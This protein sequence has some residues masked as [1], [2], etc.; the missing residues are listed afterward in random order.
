[1]A[2]LI[3]TI[4]VS[5]LHIPSAP[6]VPFFPWSPVGKPDLEVAPSKLDV[7]KRESLELINSGFSAARLHAAR[8][9]VPVNLHSVFVKAALKAGHLWIDLFALMRKHGGLRP[10]ERRSRDRG[11]QQKQNSTHNHLS[12]V[13]RRQYTA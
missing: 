6:A 9:F 7:A 4:V 13:E 10:G 11:E 2:L 8:L 5:A 3:N 1:M 12:L